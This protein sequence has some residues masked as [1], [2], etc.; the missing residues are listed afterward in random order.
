MGMMRLSGRDL[1]RELKL[2]RLMDEGELNLEE[3]VRNSLREIL[4][5]ART[6]VPYYGEVLRDSIPD[7]HPLSS[8]ELDRIPVLFRSQVQSRV[9]EPTSTDMRGTRVIT[10]TT[11]GSTGKPIRYYRDLNSH[12][13]ARA[14]EFFYYERFLEIDEISSKKLLVWGSAAELLEGI[15]LERLPERHQESCEVQ[16]ITPNK[17]FPNYYNYSNLSV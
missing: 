12:R 8:S 6:K 11:G 4:T 17:T 10:G 13:W 3:F 9:K 14:N 7:D 1:R 2:I 16:P 5:H 15:P